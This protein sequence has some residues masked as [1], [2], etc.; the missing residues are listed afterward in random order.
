MGGLCSPGNFIGRLYGE[1]LRNL[2]VMQL[3]KGYCEGLVK[4]NLLRIGCSICR[5]G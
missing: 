3:R 2:G 4:I 5:I 1:D